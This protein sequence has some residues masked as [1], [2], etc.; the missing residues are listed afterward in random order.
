MLNR[1]QQQQFVVAAPPIAK[2]I[3]APSFTPSPAPKRKPD[4]IA[5]F[6]RADALPKSAFLKPKVLQERSI[7]DQLAQVN[8][9]AKF[10]YPKMAKLKS[11]KQPLIPYLHHNGY[12][13]NIISPQQPL[14]QSPH[15]PPAPFHQ[16][17]SNPLAPQPYNIPLDNDPNFDLTRY[18][19]RA[20]MEELQQAIRLLNA[21]NGGGKVG[22]GAPA[23]Q[24]KHLSGLPNT[25]GEVTRYQAN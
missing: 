17:P 6:V 25:A 20:D 2:G 23:F 11:S 21:N 8:A 22:W 3:A 13:N 7:V 12:Q 10:P 19:N 1:P 18:H 9:A 24:S 4:P 15:H 14:R 16:Y 5:G